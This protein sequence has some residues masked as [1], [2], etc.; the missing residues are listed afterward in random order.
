V[1]AL[2][3]LVLLLLLPY[4]LAVEASAQVVR[5][6]QPPPRVIKQPVPVRPWFISGA[7][8]YP[9][10]LPRF[11]NTTP[12]TEFVESGSRNVRYAT[13]GI[14]GFDVGAGVQVMRRLFVGGA[15]SAFTG[16]SV[17]DVNAEI[18][19]PF[20]FDKKRELT[21]SVGGLERQELGV[22]IQAATILPISRRI[23]VLLAGG[24]SLFRVRQ[25]L[26]T[27]ALYSQE[28]PFDAVTFTSARTEVQAK[29]AFGF[30][31]QASLVTML[32]SRVGADVLVRYSTASVLF[33]GP[34][35]STF[36]A[37]LGGLQVGLGLR[38]IF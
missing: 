9:T 38:A 7:A 5:P 30:H 23:R 33:D 10:A 16:S 36:S 32:S 2:L 29:T 8:T 20:F 15:V 17:G 11:E 19:H 13:P 25:E 34:D 31:G 22:H 27:D 1:L 21:A 28:Y 37:S 24:P 4:T 6:T 12:I 35:G 14:P 26:V 18:P 3:R